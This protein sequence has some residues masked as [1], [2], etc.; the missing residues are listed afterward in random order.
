MALKP[1][2]KP[3]FI[4]ALKSRA[5]IKSKLI[6]VTKYKD[7]TTK[8]YTSYTRSVKALVIKGGQG[9]KSKSKLFKAIVFIL[10]KESLSSNNI[11]IEDNNKDKLIMI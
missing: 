2:L 4:R 1:A 6:K 5:V 10:S 11:N 8:L 3:K 9:T 7:K